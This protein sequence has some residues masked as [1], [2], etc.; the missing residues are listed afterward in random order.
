LTESQ[1]I[2]SPDSSAYTITKININS[3]EADICAVPY[4]NGIVFSSSRNN[5]PR[6]SQKDAWTGQKYLSIYYAK[7]NQ[8]Q[9]NKPE[10]FASSIQKKFNNGPVSFTKSGDEIYFTINTPNKD[11]AGNVNIRKLDIF[12]SKINGNKF[13]TPLPFPYNNNKYSCAHPA[14]SKDGNV[15]YFSSD[16][17]GTFGGMDLWVSKKENGLWSVPENLGENINTPG[18]EIFPVIN[19]STLFYSSD[20]ATGIGGLDIFSSEIDGENYSVP[21]NLVQFNSSDDDFGFYS[22]AGMNS[23]YFCSNRTHQG[24]NDDIYFFN[25]NVSILAGLVIDKTTKLPVTNSRIVMQRPGEEDKILFTDNEGRF[26]DTL[27]AG[28]TYNITA[29]S[30]NYLS[31]STTITSFGQPDKATVSLTMEL[32]SEQLLAGSDKEITIEQFDQEGG[33]IILKNILYDL[34]KFN[35]RKDATA[36]LQKVAAL[37]NKY[38]Q[39]KIELSSHTDCRSTAK[40]NLW[41]SKMRAGAAVD[42]LIAQGID[43]NRLVPKGY[44]ETMPLIVCESPSGKRLS[45]TE[46]EHQSNRR[47]EIKIIAVGPVVLSQR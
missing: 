21:K 17:N 5:S 22:D 31:A 12:I 38:P 44:G 6:S 24:L 15:L 41:L 47:T 8:A 26:S 45:C 13:S 25:R 36:E 18:N 28:S 10:I 1:V 19:G 34:N 2:D 27:T 16:M 46:A 30:K 40:F 3:P 32:V 23:G 9:F 20:G 7:G 43:R 35:I 42:Y 4:Q 37:M 11:R 33:K 29:E 39:L 14:I